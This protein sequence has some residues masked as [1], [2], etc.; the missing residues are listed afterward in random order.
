MTF[1][2]CL[3]EMIF[4]GIRL[5]FGHGKYTS[6]FCSK[7]RIMEIGWPCYERDCFDEVKLRWLSKD[8]RSSLFQALIVNQVSGTAGSIAVSS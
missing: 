1:W 4:S 5:I 7:D 2:T 8:K 6:C 3:E